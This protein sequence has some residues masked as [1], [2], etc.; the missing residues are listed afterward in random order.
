[1]DLEHSSFDSTLNPHYES[2]DLSTSMDTTIQNY[3]CLSQGSITL[4][5]HRNKDMTTHHVHYNGAD[6]EN[7]ENS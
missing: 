5:H 3:T 7:A 6:T 1:M 2:A 4:A